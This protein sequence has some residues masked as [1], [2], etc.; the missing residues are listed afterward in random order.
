M[1]TFT[2]PVTF[3]HISS[4]FCAPGLLFLTISSRWPLQAQS[5][6]ETDWRRM[7]TPFALLYF[8]LPFPYDIYG[9]NSSSLSAMRREG[10]SQG[11]Q[12]L[13]QVRLCEPAGYSRLGYQTRVLALLEHALFQEGVVS[14]ALWGKT[15][16]VDLTHETSCIQPL[17]SQ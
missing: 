7:L 2:F 4:E 8:I 9:P 3:I 14:F 15:E 12:S 10:H 5:P 11:L 6:M 17:P 13:L 16:L 1:G